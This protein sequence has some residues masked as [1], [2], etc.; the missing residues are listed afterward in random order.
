MATTK[1]RRRLLDKVRQRAKSRLVKRHYA[2]FVQIYEEAIAEEGE[3]PR[4]PKFVECG[5]LGNE[6]KGTSLR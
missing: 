3:K 6:M 2:E 1:K 5:H 4:N